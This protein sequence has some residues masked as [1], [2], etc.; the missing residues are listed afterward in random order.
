M[1]VRTASNPLPSLQAPGSWISVEPVDMA[2][3]IL[4]GVL[5]RTTQITPLRPGVRQALDI[6]ATEAFAVAARLVSSVGTDSYPVSMVE[7]VR[8]FVPFDFF[9]VVRYPREGAPVL[10]NDNLSAAT[11]PQVIAD[12]KAG[13]YLLDPVY[14]ACHHGSASGVHRQIDLAPDNFSQSEFFC[15]GQLYPCVSDKANALAEEIVYIFRM[16]DESC[17]VLSLMRDKA[18]KRFDTTEFLRLSMLEPII[19]ETLIRHWPCSEHEAKHQI[20]PRRPAGELE[21]AFSEFAKY[22]LSSREQTVVSLLLRGHSTLSIAHN[23]CIAEGTVKIHRKH[24]YEKLCISSQA[25]L[26][27]KFCNHILEDRVGV[28]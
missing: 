9:C 10:L 1:P 8:R 14:V 4:Q 18:H 17:L 11:S 13:T 19:R 20:Q 16:P 3:Y 22:T 5:R 26:F 6:T 24:I 27:L 25:Q 2:R 23:L 28:A 7:S 12:Y 21:K 15:S